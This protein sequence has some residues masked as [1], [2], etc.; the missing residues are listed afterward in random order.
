MFIFKFG[1][2][3]FNNRIA[4]FFPDFPELTPISFY[5]LTVFIYILLQGELWNM[6]SQKQINK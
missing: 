6:A 4:S 5:Q 3:V 2:D 1:L